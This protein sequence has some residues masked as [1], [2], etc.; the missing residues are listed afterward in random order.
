MLFPLIEA[1]ANSKPRRDARSAVM[2]SEW[3]PPTRNGSKLKPRAGLLVFCSNL[4]GGIGGGCR[5]SSH[6]CTCL[7]K[8][9]S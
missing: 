5:G 7:Y 9:A 4:G 3:T 2:F 8:R 6:A 1:A